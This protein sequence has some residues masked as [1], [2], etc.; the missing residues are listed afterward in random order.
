MS[1]C[2]PLK[3]GGK[4]VVLGGSA[5]LLQR[6]PHMKLYYH[7]KLKAFSRDLRKKRVLSEVL[8]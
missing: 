1:W 7:P 6:N 2:F 5:N 3:K 4:G 8:L